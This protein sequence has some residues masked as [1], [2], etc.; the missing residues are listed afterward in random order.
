MHLENLKN[1][2]FYVINPDTIWTKA[3][4]KEFKK[5]VRSYMINKKSTM[6]LVQKIKVSIN[7]LKEIFV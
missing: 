6:L 2:I 7:R 5:L 1:Q 3:Y 4:K